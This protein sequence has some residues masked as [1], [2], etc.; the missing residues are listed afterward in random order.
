MIDQVISIALKPKLVWALI[1][2][3]IILSMRGLFLPLFGDEI[4]YVNIASNIIDSGS[5]LLNDS[6]STVIPIVPGILALWSSLFGIENGII[7]SRLSHLVIAIIGFYYAYKLLLTV[8]KNSSISLLLLLLVVVNSNTVAGICNLYPDSILFCFL[9]VLLF[10]LTKRN[11]RLSDWAI[12]L[13]STLILIMTRYSY[14]VLGLPILMVYLRY[15]KKH[16]YELTQVIYLLGLTLISILPLVFWFIY[17]SDVEVSQTKGISYFHRFKNHG[18][19]YNIKAGLGF[20]KHDEVGKVNGIPAFASVFIPITGLRSWLLSVPILII[21]LYG[22]LQ[23][24]T[25]TI[26][27]IFLSIVLIMLGFVFAGT[28]FSRYW[29]TLMPAFYLGIYFTSQKLKIP[30]RLFKLA[31]IALVCIYMLNEFRLTYLILK[32]FY[33]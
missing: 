21:V 6:R 27:L 4:T 33:S 1:T 8:L 16:K 28:G 30:N 31:G 25:T 5:Y 26:K 32:N 12:I 15:L 22:Y 7:L 17:V 9:W 10:Y 29:L 23:Q 13:F 2:T 3:T 14:A 19:W 11:L 24:N 18:L 20:I